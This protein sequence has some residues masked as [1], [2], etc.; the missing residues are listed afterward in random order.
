VVYR[1]E[2]FAGDNAVCHGF[3]GG[4]CAA[5]EYTHAVALWRGLKRGWGRKVPPPLLMAQ[6]HGAAIADADALAGRRRTVDVLVAPGVDGVESA[7]GTALLLVV[8]SADCVPVLAVNYDLGRCAVLHAGWRGV[9]AGILPALLERWRARGSRLET[10]R[11]AFGPHIRSCC[12]QVQQ[13]CVQRFNPPDLNGAM[14]TRSGSRYI[15]LE[16]VLRT[17]ASRFGIVPEQIETLPLCTDCTRGPD[18]APLFASYRRANRMGAP[19]G[20]NLSFITLLPHLP[21]RQ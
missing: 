10:V 3:T 7:A 18:G 2:I 12:F 21:S 1:A 6:P 5:D 4:F 11:L 9:A 13:D 16:T 15:A 20:R 14:E 8:K 17:Q 19:V